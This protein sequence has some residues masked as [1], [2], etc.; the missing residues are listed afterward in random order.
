MISKIF[1]D[2]SREPGSPCG[3]VPVIRVVVVVETTIVVVEL[4]VN[5]VKAD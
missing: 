3:K 5:S 4:N 1:L 2:E